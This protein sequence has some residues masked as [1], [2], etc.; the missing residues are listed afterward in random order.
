[1]TTQRINW[2]GWNGMINSPTGTRIAQGSGT[3][4]RNSVHMEDKD[5]DNQSNFSVGNVV[6]GSINCAPSASANSPIIEPSNANELY[7]NNQNNENIS[8]S[9]SASEAG[10]ISSTQENS[11]ESK[12]TTAT[13]SY[14]DPAYES[15]VSNDR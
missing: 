14:S 6:D 9:E 1:M 3:E 5:G 11:R 15:K 12:Q 13:I 7:K 8:Q 10:V 2:F 4:E